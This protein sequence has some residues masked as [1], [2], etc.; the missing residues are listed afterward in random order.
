MKLKIN[1]IFLYFLVEN[2]FGLSNLEINQTVKAY[3]IQNGIF[4]NFSINKK[5]KLPNCEKNIEVKKKFNTFKTLEIACLQDN[6]WT[7]NIRVKIQNDKKKFKQ[8]LKSK[9]KEIKLIKLNKNLKKGHIITENDIIVVKTN[10]KGASN[11]FSNKNEVL[12][13]KTKT[14]IR[15]GQILRQRHIRKNW[16]IIE[17]QRI[18]IEN[19]KSKIQVLIEGEALKSAMSGDYV[20]VLN[21]STGKSVKAWVKNNKK[22][23]I[24]R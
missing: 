4:Q 14:F 6:P 21:K 24:F 2:A 7:Y 5:L 11:Y 18:I 3:L 22:V 10:Q 23:S 12:G 8:K 13:K 16:T 15:E 19:N 1:I 20:E 17:G 9:N